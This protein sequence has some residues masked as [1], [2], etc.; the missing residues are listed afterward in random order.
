MRSHSIAIQGSLA[1]FHELAAKHYFGNDIE[2]IYCQS[3][4]EVC[5]KIAANQADYGLI[6]I[7]NKVAG[8]ILL[9]YQLIESFGLSIIGET[10]LPVELQ[11]LGKK[12]S[13]ISEIREIISHPMALAQCQQFL[14]G[15]DGVTVSEFRDTAGAAQ[16][17]ASGEDRTIA[18][19]AGPAAAKHLQLEILSGD[20]CDTSDNYTRFYALS[21]RSVVIEEANKASVTVRLKNEPGTLSDL[22]VILKKA[23][24]N[25]TKIQSIPVPGDDSHYSFHLDLS[26]GSRSGL[27]RA[28]TEATFLTTEMH[29]LGIYEGKLPPLLIHSIL[30]NALI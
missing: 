23:N 22:L 5:S 4:R 27:D 10:Y 2:P 19:I 3:F 17:I 26:F 29:I 9:N 20:I 28:L 7:E 16:L 30:Q 6:A 12:G 14:S 11:L 21:K 13:V 18:A 25:V 8:S 15:L 1:S 24:I